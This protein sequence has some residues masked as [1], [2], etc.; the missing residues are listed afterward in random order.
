MQTVINLTQNSSLNCSFNKQKLM[1][2]SISG[3]PKFHDDTVLWCS[4]RPIHHYQLALRY[5]PRLTTLLW[6]PWSKLRR[7]Y[8]T[9]KGKIFV[10]TSPSLPASSNQNLP[11]LLLSSLHG[12]TLLEHLS[13]SPSLVWKDIAQWW[14]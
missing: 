1:V 8:P 10:S 4:I 6:S 3:L 11:F 12:N 14:G 9:C 5:L 13:L 2:A 7:L